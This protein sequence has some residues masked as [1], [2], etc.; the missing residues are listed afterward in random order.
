MNKLYIR[1]L[2]A[3]SVAGALT[4]TLTWAQQRG[5]GRHHHHHNHNHAR[6]GVYVGAPLFWS[7]FWYPYPYPYYY[8]YSTVVVQPAGPV[9]YVEK[10][11]ATQ[12][13]APAPQ[14]QQQ[15]WHYCPDSSTYYP[16]VNTCASPWQRVIPHPP[17]PG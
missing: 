12:S 6:V 15:Y 1:L 9:V 16:Y 11:D 8:P 14:A 17:P 5:G 2:V 10:A 13:A 3:A 4:S 7:P